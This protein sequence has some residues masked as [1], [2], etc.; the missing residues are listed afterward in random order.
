MKQRNGGSKWETQ[1][2]IQRQA[3]RL[4]WQSI[5]GRDEDPS[6]VCLLRSWARKARR[7]RRLGLTALFTSLSLPTSRPLSAFRNENLVGFPGLAVFSVQSYHQLGIG[8][9]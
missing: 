3:H 9:S 2:V 6:V 8:S 1:Q 4:G 5:L 7:L